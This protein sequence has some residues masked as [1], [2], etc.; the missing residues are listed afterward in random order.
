MPG[1]Y[2]PSQGEGQQQPN[3]T[4]TAGRSAR[5]S[6]PW[7]AGSAMASR[8]RRA[9]I[10]GLRT[11]RWCRATSRVPGDPGRALAADHSGRLSRRSGRPHEAHPLPLLVT[12]VDADGNELSG[13]RLPNVAVPLATYT[14]WNFRSP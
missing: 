11:T 1:G 9:R 14:G 6:S 10:H 3:P 2:L 4:N 5:S 13:I 7:T 12:Q 8:H